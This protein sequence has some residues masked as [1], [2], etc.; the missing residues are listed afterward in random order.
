MTVYKYRAITGEG[1][2]LEGTYNAKNKEEVVLMLRENKYYPVDIKE[3]RDGKDIRDFWI[4]SRVKIKDIAIFCR[5]FYT[6]F[7]AG[8]TII[9][10]LDI[11][12]Q[13]TENKKL[14]HVIGKVYEEV[15]KGLTFS[16][17]LK[18]TKIYFQGY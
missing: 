17:A 13:Q 12:H 2:P 5:Q 7:N 1:K 3:A 16:E 6:M 15:Q 18:N 4:F 10:C 8:V 11:L 14:K 9:S